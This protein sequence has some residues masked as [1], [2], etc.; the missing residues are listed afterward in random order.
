MAALRGRPAERGFRADRDAAYALRDPDARETRFRAIHAAWFRRLDLDRPLVE[1]LRAEPTVTARASRCLAMSVPSPRD[2][3]AELFVAPGAGSPAAAQRT[4]VLGLRPETF[5]DP[6]RLLALCRRE[7]LHIAD[8]LDPDFGYTPRPPD[9][10]A[11]PL[12]EPLFRER[13]RALWAAS[14]D[15]RLVRRGWAPSDL[16]AERAR[17]LAAAFPR[18]GASLEALVERLFTGPRPTHAELV[19]LA[20]APAPLPGARGGGPR[21]GERCPLCGCP[22]HAFEADPL[23]LPPA[24]RAWIRRSAPDWEPAD[25]LCGR[26]ADLFR[27]RA[28][29]GAPA[30]GSTAPAERGA[31]ASG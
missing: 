17:E 15:G 2:E 23:Q 12:P 5:A 7:L 10:A 16:R 28:Q 21:P 13:Y 4:V 3:R 31:S 11:S 25:G 22:T 8:L 30:P 6:D 29:T 14:V 26:C 20:L 18:L 19:R 24:A 9:L 1:A 27:A